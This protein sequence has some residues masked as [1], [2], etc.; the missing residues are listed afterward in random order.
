MSTTFL[1]PTLLLA[2]LATTAQSLTLKQG[3]RPSCGG[4]VVVPYP[5]GIGQG[6]FLP[7]FEIMCDNSRP[8]LGNTGQA[9]RVFVLSMSVTPR[10]EARVMVP[11]TWQCHNS[12]GDVVDWHIKTVDY[13]PASVYRISN[14]HNELFIIGCNTFAY[15]N[16]GP[17]GRSMYTYYMGCAAYCDNAR[18][19]GMA[20]AAESAAAMSISHGTFRTTG[21]RSRRIRVGRTRAWNSASATTPS[22]WRRATTSS[23]RLTS[24]W[25]SRPASRCG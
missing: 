9:L 23:R 19:R 14:I 17:S 2:A 18:A 5:F 1:L 6:C 10:P 16:S 15:T 13:N 24:K 8:I 11:I 21:C 22:S 4:V 25:T 7:G 3:C 20:S 12:S